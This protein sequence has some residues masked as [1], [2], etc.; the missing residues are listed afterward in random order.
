MKPVV[1]SLLETDLYKFTMWQ[2]LLHSHPGAQAEYAFVCRNAPVYP[3][4]ELAGD[5]NRELDHLCMMSFSEDELDYLR[6]LRYIKSDFVDFLAV[7]RFQRKFVTVET[8]GPTLVIRAKGPQVHVMGFEI[9]V[10]YIVNELYFRRFDQQAALSEGRKRLA[11]K[12]TLLREFGTEPA[13]RHP[14]AL[15]SPWSQLTRCSSVV[16]G[17]RTRDRST[18]SIGSASEITMCSALAASICATSVEPQRDM[19]NTKP[20][21]A[22][23]GHA[24]SSSCNASTGVRIGEPRRP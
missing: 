1:R 10:L 18:V 12:I 22:T 4:S 24:S 23:P 20:D 17:S 11:D 7:F 8:D 13:R 5:V 9:F 15:I 19:W 14:Y 16:A 3:L 6:K 2:A 21:G